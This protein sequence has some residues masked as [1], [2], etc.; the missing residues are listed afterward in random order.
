MTQIKSLLCT[1]CLIL[2]TA[3]DTNH[4]TFKISEQTL[5]IPNEYVRTEHL[6]IR[7]A[8]GF[9]SDGGT[10]WLKIY[11]TKIANKADRSLFDNIKEY[12]GFEERGRFDFEITPLKNMDLKTKTEPEYATTYYNLEDYVKQKDSVMP[13]IIKNSEGTTEAI[14]SV[15]WRDRETKKRSCSNNVIHGSIV[16]EYY[17]PLDYMMQPGRKKQLDD[18]LRGLIDQWVVKN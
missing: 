8:P 11:T 17:L 18:Y 7:D 12:R 6:G 2:T 4:Y 10:I 1:L 5:K 9:D 13:G 16:F 3:C 15:G 14:C